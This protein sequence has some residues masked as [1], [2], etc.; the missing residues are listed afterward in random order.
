MTLERRKRR[1][2]IVEEV[3]T[4][5]SLGFDNKV[6]LNNQQKIADEFDEQ[7]I[8]YLHQSITRQP[9]SSGVRHYITDVTF[10]TK[11]ILTQKVRICYQHLSLSILKPLIFSFGS[12]NR[13][14]HN[15]NLAFLNSMTI[16]PMNLLASTVMTM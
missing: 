2:A 4:S 14:K 15:D 12:Y 1:V 11:A 6:V 3:N 5:S 9:V 7:C 8:T 16:A 10:T 13:F